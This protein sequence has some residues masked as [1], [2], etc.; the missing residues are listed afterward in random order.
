MMKT[1]TLTLCLGAL[2]L[3]GCQEP[4]GQHS[5]V[6]LAEED[7]TQSG[8]GAIDGVAEPK[9][10]GQ[11]IADETAG[12]VENELTDEDEAGIAGQRYDDD[13]QEP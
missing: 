8:D 7:P 9:T 2:S 10:P 13:P 4:Q 3:A 12:S 5:D 1:A 11:A 6:E